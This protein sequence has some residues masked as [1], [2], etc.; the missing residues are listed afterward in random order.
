MTTAVVLAR[1]PRTETA[2]AEAL[3]GALPGPVIALD[4]EDRFRFANPA[5]EQFFGAGAGLVR[6]AALARVH[7]G[8]TTPPGLL[9]L[10][11]RQATAFHPG[12]GSD[13]V[14][15][16][17]GVIEPCLHKWLEEPA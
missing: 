6:S 12:L 13:L 7:P 5:A 14:A 9:A 4:G 10:G 2:D 16:L 3:L 11:A 15:F 1:D 17:A 8:A